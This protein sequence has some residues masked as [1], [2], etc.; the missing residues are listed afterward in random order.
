MGDNINL[1]SICNDYSMYKHEPTENEK[2]ACR[3]L[4]KNWQL[5]RSIQRSSSDQNEWCKNI[6][7]WLYYEIN[8]Y[9]LNDDIINRI[10][11]EAQI[12]FMH[13]PNTQYC[14]FTALNVNHE[15]KELNKLRIF[16]ENTSTFNDILKEK[17]SDNY[18]SC[19]NF[20]KDCINIYKN[21]NSKHCSTTIDTSN[22]RTCDI[23]RDFYLYYTGY[24]HRDIKIQEKLPDLFSTTDINI[25]IEECRS[26]TNGKGLDSLRGGLS[27]GST[28]STTPAET[29]GKT[30]PT[31]IGTIAG[32]SS[33]LAL[34][35]KVISNF[36][37]NM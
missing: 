3:K 5:L 11:V 26:Q 23:V 28:V 21:I 12:K 4:L 1:F 8:P 22:E 30:V 17:S 10:L 25:D 24:L 7:N 34:L 18:C 33:V 9:I 16:N 13:V 32:V 35:Y 19:R 2:Y 6:N 36:Y 20:V 14:S 27:D 15:P 29:A 31:A 37:L